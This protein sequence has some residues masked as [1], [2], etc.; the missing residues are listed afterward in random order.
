MDD[1]FAQ[2]EHD[3]PLVV[4]DPGTRVVDQGTMV[5]PPYPAVTMLVVRS[6]P[7]HGAHCWVDEPAPEVRW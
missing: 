5:W 1:Q 2:L 6:G 7:Y 3:G 4:L